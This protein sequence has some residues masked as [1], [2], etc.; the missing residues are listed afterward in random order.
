MPDKMLPLGSVVELEDG[1]YTIIGYLP[2]Q[3][4]DGKY[5]I[6]EYVGC[7]YLKG[8]EIDKTLRHFS[9]NSILNVY[10]IGY[11]NDEF[12]KYLDVM[13]YFF[14]SI[15]PNGSIEEA[16]EKVGSRYFSEDKQKYIEILN[17]A[18]DLTIGKESEVVK[19]E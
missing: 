13:D 16:L 1:K 4:I 11:K 7:P 14:K 17:N 18:I 10:F 12:D 19:D 15:K 9:N 8:Y 5:A 3:V 2:Y 6:D